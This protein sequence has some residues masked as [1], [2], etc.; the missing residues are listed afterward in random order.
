MP[1]NSFIIQPSENDLRAAYRPIILKVAATSTIGGVQPPYVS[2]DIY[3]NDVYYKSIIRTAPESITDVD[4][5]FIF[6]IQTALQEYLAVDIP[7]LDNQNVLMAT[8]TSAKVFCRFRASDIV[9]GFTVE[10]GTKPIQGTKF[11]DPVSGDGLES[12]AFFV[13]NSALQHEDNPDLATHLTASRQGTWAEGAYP[14]T[15]RRNYYF[16]NED[17]DHFPF[18]YSGDCLEVDLRLNYR[19]KG[20]TS[21][22]S[23]DVS[24]GSS[25]VGIDYTATPAG[26]TVNVVMASAPGA[27]VSFKVQIK[28]QAD[29]VWT[30]KGTFTVQNFSFNVSEI[31]DYDIRIITFCSACASAAPIEHTFSIDTIVTVAW[32]GI[33]PFC[34]Q[35]TFETPIYVVLELRNPVTDDS[36]FPSDDIRFSRNV[37]TTYDLYA[38]FYSDATHLTPLSVTQ[39]GLNVFVKQRQQQTSEPGS[40]NFDSEILQTY[41]VDAAGVEVLLANVL[42]S[43]DI[44]NYSTYPTVTSS[45][46]NDYTYSMFPTHLLVGGNTG[47]KGY[48]DLEEYNTVTNAATGT[49]KTN[50][51]SDP[52]YIAPVFDTITCPAGPDYLSLLYGYSL[53]VA[54][55]EFH[56]G[57]SFIYGET[58]TDTDAGGFK[59]I[60]NVPKNI[61][62]SIT[63]KA[64]TLDSGNTTGILKVRVVY[65]NAGVSTTATFDIPDNIETLLPQ[66]FQNIVSVNISNY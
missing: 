54:K 24:G 6:D 37:E 40:H 38:K 7:P 21:F 64:K 22:T 11:T 31:G 3:I 8:H 23:E 44:T 61:N 32:R 15:H 25:C 12:E 39:A 4:S 65:I 1:V 46:A 36:F 43:L 60:Y 49:T 18:L 30:D 63:V 35:Q 53:Q 47:Y 51:D 62:T 5:I 57:A 56:T 20:E 58:E 48:A 33:H 41:T 59:F 28:L 27:G 16:C 50:V 45:Q 66:V 55:V 9:D 2:C 13:I 14:L 26:N 42:T 17:S 52:D 29:S 10:E 19:L 34:V